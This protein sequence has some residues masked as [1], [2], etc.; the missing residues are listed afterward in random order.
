VQPFLKGKRERRQ[1]SSIVPEADDIAKSCVV[2][3]EV[4]GG[5]LHLEVEDD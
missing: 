4:K 3:G 1:D 2:T 5:D